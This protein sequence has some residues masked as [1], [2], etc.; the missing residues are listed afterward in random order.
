MEESRLYGWENGKVFG[1]ILA[2]KQNPAMALYD[3]D[4]DIGE[5]KNIAEQYP[6]IIKQLTATW[7]RSTNLIQTILSPRIRTRSF[8]KSHTISEFRSVWL[9]FCPTKMFKS[10]HC[11]IFSVATTALVS[12]A[13]SSDDPGILALKAFEK[14]VR[15]VL[16]KHRFN[17]H[18]PEKQKGKVRLDTLNPD[19]VNS[20]SAETWHDALDNINLGEMPPEDEPAISDQDQKGAH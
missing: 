6:E 17:C 4:A 12:Y 7:M 20:T 3:L 18:G 15:P 13:Y 10:K 9:L 14:D 16:E 19:L 11:T 1:K 5:T 8:L 2:R